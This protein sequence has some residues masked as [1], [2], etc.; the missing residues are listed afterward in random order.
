VLPVDPG[1]KL[2]QDAL[3]A[4]S[5]NERH[6]ASLDPGRWT[7]SSDVI[8][9]SQLIVDLLRL[10]HGRSTSQLETLRHTTSPITA[11]LATSF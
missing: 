8:P 11:E 9:A 5:N 6:R 2:D 7:G 3:Q 1:V 4:S 10:R